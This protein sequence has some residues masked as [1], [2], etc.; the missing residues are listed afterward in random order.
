MKTLAVLLLSGLLAGPASADLIVTRGT[1]GVAHYTNDGVSLA[2]SSLRERE[3]CR[4][5]ASG[6]AGWRR[7][8][9]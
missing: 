9:R 5:H 1:L 6:S 3:D 7:S 4:T 2:R 8:L